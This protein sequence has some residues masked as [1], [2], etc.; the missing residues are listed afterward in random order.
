MLVIWLLE[1][2]A[3]KEFPVTLEEP[4]KEF[5]SLPL[6]AKTMAMHGSVTRKRNRY[7]TFVIRDIHTGG[8][9]SVTSAE[10]LLLDG[11]AGR[12]I[13]VA[14]PLVLFRIDYGFDPERG[15]AAAIFDA[16]AGK[17]KGIRANSMRQLSRRCH[18]AICEQENL[19]RRFPLEMEKASPPVILHPDYE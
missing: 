1:G 19:R 3:G 11:Y 6:P 17:S 9:R 7:E 15:Y 18:E 14:K 8:L 16:Q 10:N 5:R 13:T 2:G 4:A 12:K